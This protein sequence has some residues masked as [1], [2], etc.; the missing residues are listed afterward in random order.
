MSDAR[1]FSVSLPPTSWLA[2]RWPLLLLVGM[3]VLVG[4]LLRFNDIEKKSLWS[5]ELFTLAIA[6]YH[7]LI[8]EAGQR[9]YRATT[10]YEVRDEDSFLT[11]KAAEQSPPLQDLLEKASVQWLGPTELGARLPGAIAACVLLVWFAWFAARASDPWQRRVL[12]WSLLFIALS[13]AL[14][15]FARD[16]RAYSLGATLVGMGSLLWMLRWQRGWRQVEPPGWTEIALFT[17]ACYTHYNAAALVAILLLP[18]AVVAWH[19]RSKVAWKRLLTLGGIFLIWLLL[20]ARTIV[21]T[22]KGGVAWGQFTP[23]QLATETVKGTLTILHPYWLLLFVA[24]AWSLLAW[25]V[26]KSGAVVLPAR[27]VAVFALLTI[28]V[29]F[30]ALAGKIVARAGMAHPRYYIF[31]VPLMAVAFAI[32]FAELRQRWMVAVALV[33]VV[34]A[35]SRDLRHPGLINQDNFRDMSRAALQGTSADTP[36]LYPWKPNRNTYRIYLERFAGTDMRSRMVPVS[37]PGDVD[38]VC[39]RLATAPHV[40]VIGH[41]SGNQRINEVYARCGARWPHRTRQE[42]R[43]TFTEHWRASA[44]VSPAAR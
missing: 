39:D 28:T 18:D 16:G 2:G 37:M 14:V 36:V 10:I 33:L 31:I 23:Q 19:R 4:S 26:V 43:N 40:A 20:A 30:V 21:F 12:L 7:P 9:M 17:L 5:D 11:A 15:E 34:A 29:V 8:P 6:Q 25:R 32:V 1:S 35:V 44:P 41:E 38:G 3:L 42:F 24:L 13:P 27:A 22:A